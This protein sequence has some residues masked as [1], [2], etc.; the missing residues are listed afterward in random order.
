M[1]N[2]GGKQPLP[3]QKAEETAN[4]ANIILRPK[5][6]CHKCMIVES[7][8]IADMMLS[9]IYGEGGAKEWPTLSPNLPC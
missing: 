9:Q 7:D 8:I 2:E 4:Q 6:F 1:R 5:Q 3:G